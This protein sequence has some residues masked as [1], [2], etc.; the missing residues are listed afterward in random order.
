MPTS[1]NGTRWDG[2]RER[3]YE[4]WYGIF[5]RPETRE[6]WWMRY[7]LTNPLSV[8][9]GMGAGLWFNYVNLAETR[10]S[11]AVI[12]HF[13][14]SAFTGE[15]ISIAGAALTNGSMSGAFDEAGHSVAWNL[16]YTPSPATHYFFPE[17]LRRA[18]Q[19]I[20]S[21]TMPNP[22]VLA[23]GDV[24][25][26][27]QK[28]TLDGVRGHTCH[29]WGKRRAKA[30][31]WAHCN[32]FREDKSAIVEVLYP[33]LPPLPRP[34]FVNLYI[35][36][37]HIFVGGFTGGE[38]TRSGRLWRYVGQG[39]AARV[40]VTFTAPEKSILR[41][42]YVSPDG[43]RSNV[44]SSLLSE[45]TVR[46]ERRK[47]RFAS[48]EPAETLTGIGPAEEVTPEVVTDLDRERLPGI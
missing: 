1:P 19:S 13:P 43:N 23:S 7:T 3:F 26:D 39:R 41:L 30:W 42:G 36:G 47:H 8:D 48:F 29:H 18:T 44:F 38:T 10:R 4:V 24:T 17:W 16:R 40:T 14:A 33:T 25:I 2:Q 22:L 15:P 5:T 27:G 34:T 12:K 9:D 46:V 37:E 45:C 6:A 31:R 20:S 11:V 35:G 28:M 21:V 32:D